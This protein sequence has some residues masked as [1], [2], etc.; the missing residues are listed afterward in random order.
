MLPPE[1]RPRVLHRLAWLCAVLVFAITS[2]SAF[3]RLSKTGVGC[4][5]WPQCYAQ[6]AQSAQQGQAPE[7]ALDSAITP[8]RTVHRV[9]AVVALIVI[10]MLVTAALARPVLWPELRMASALLALALFLAVLGRWTAGSRMPAI[11]L[12]NLLGGFAMFAVSVRLVLQ[13]TA[14]PIAVPRAGPALSLYAWCA[15]ALVFVDVALG[16]LVPAAPAGSFDQLALTMHWLG[17]AGVFAVSLPL[18][19]LAWR[20]GQRRAGAA[21]LVLL[22]VQV[23]LAAILSFSSV[24]LGVVLAHNVAA[25]LLLAGLVLIAARR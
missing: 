16:G 19:V 18:G 22:A 7:A 14:K 10:L 9:V 25:S 2:L 12:G 23:A 3:I 8:A 5:P 15:A 20:K 11:T 17:A 6:S 1:P 4:D 13:A 21:V 24:R